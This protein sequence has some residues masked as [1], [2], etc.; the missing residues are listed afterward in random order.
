MHACL[1]NF[2]CDAVGLA[3][4]L[5][6]QSHRVDDV[7]PLERAYV[8]AA[9]AARI[10][11]ILLQ[12]LHSF[13]QP[14]A[15]DGRQQVGKGHPADWQHAADLY[16]INRQWLDR[17]WALEYSDNFKAHVLRRRSALRDLEGRRRGLRAAKLDPVAMCPPQMVQAVVEAHD[18]ACAQTVSLY[19]SVFYDAVMS[20][21][22]E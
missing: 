21:D 13:P 12:L 22:P 4:S 15:V 1:I 11:P 3:R 7:L 19:H 10:T 18:R 8:N 2:P 17:P 20:I 5:F 9:D 6:L 16:D 14:P